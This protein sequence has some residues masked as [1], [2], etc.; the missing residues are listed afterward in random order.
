MV[1]KTKTQAQNSSQKLKKKTQ[2]PGGF[3]QKLKKVEKITHIWMFFQGGDAYFDISIVKY[4][5]KREFSYSN[6]QKV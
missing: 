6:N 5:Q 2:A 1:E 4:V 3:F